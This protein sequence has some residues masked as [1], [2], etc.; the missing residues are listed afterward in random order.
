M[1]TDALITMGGFILN[2]IL[3][4]FPDT[5]PPAW[6]ETANQYFPTVFQQAHA[7]GVWL[8]W[9]VLGIVILA[10]MAGYAVGFGL[11]FLRI[12]QSTFTGGG[13]GAA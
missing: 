1:I 3:G 13:G 5:E 10:T 11:K 4:F 7:M 8:P 2:A 9:D 6:M 12:V